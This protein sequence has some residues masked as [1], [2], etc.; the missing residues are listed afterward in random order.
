MNFGAL[1]LRIRSKLFLILLSLIAMS[2]LVAYFSARAE[3]ERDAKER[4]T[5]DLV[6]RAHLVAHAAER[7]TSALDDFAAWDALADR[8]G[9]DAAARV[10]IVSKTGVVLGDSQV[11]TA[12]LPT[13]DNHGS[14]PEIVTALSGEIGKSRRHSATIDGE[15]VYVAVPLER[16]G[17][18]VGVARV[19]MQLTQIDTTLYT[20]RE[21]LIISAA[22][23]FAVAVL[24]TSLAVQ[25]VSRT[26]LTL[27]ESAR[28]M[29]AGDLH[30]RIAT[31]GHDEFADLGRA[32]NRLAKNLSSTLGAL[33]EERDRMGGILANMDEGVLFL[34]ES[35][36]VALINPKLRE[37]LVLQGKQ[38]GNTLL[39]VI[40]HAELLDLLDQAR[41]GRPVEGEIEVTGLRPS[42]LMVRATKLE[43]AQRGVLAVFIDVTETRRLEGIRREFVANV[44]HELRTPVTSIRSAGESLSMA[45]SQ[46]DM[47]Q[48][49][50]DIIDRNGERLQVL[51]EDLLE[52]SRIESKQYS[53]T[54][55]P[56][57]VGPF[58]MQ[59]LSLFTDRAQ[60]A[61]VKLTPEFA[62]GLPPA[63]ADRRALEHVVTNL[64]DNAIKY[65]GPS[66]QVVV[67]VEPTESRILI[68]VSDNGP[69]IPE[70]H[71]P[72][73][74]ERFYRIDAGRSRELGGTGLGLSI[75][76]N[77]TESMGGT[78]RVE[79]QEGIG[80]TFEVSLPRV[81]KTRD[82]AA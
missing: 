80:T 16:D 53:P 57:D 41:V 22:L 5:E 30:V 67:S 69:G 29:A 52:L 70:K 82:R 78:V 2:V 56:L 40:R 48:K 23:A 3:I 37:M 27:T 68:R 50:V 38:E 43:G 79:S 1:R 21:A 77:L 76:K 7:A 24:V 55:E 46:P 9:H 25:L 71:L 54:P 6:V 47:A 20:L 61:D 81:P 4:I 15:L 12:E 35:G 8:L 36:R 65:A 58:V 63:H 45:L 64:V 18:V 44:S 59:M 11:P 17:E 75:V 13:V 19:S 60:R 66:K 26:A 14:R 34:D 73:V 33:R 51:V 42:K 74:F 32:L 39:E 31:D 72:R 10:T 49:F 28:R 62:E